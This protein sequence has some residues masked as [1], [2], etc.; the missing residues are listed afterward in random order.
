MYQVVV[1]NELYFYVFQLI[2]FNDIGSKSI[3]NN[4]T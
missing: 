3:Q 4:I 1:M 2:L